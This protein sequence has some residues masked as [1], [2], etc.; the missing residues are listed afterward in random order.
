MDF[1]TPIEVIAGKDYTTVPA[2]IR[3]SMV[4]VEAEDQNI[5]IE[6][7]NWRIGERV[8]ISLWPL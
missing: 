6:M 1:R 4:L 8:L 2:H 7:S 3:D 5:G